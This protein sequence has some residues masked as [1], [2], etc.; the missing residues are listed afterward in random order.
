ML[1]L[2]LR[3]EI[4][5]VAPKK[6]SRH[7]I[8]SVFCPNFS[9]QF[10]GSAPWLGQLWLYGYQRLREGGRYCFSGSPAPN[11]SATKSEEV[12]RFRL[13]LKP[14]CRELPY[15][16]D[17]AETLPLATVMPSKWKKG[18]GKVGDVSK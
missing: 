13:C 16:V 1:W 8:V 5:N 17:E 6:R 4:S 11:S 10:L 9:A 12:Q 18:G 2:L 7:I 14:T 15:T 3:E